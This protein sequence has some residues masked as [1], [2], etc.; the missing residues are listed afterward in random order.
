[1]ILAI[2]MISVVV[3]FG[4]RFV[5]RRTNVEMI[6]VEMRSAVWPGEDRLIQVV[7]AESKSASRISILDL[8]WLPIA[9]ITDYYLLPEGRILRCSGRGINLL[10]WTYP[11]PRRCGDPGPA[12][13]DILQLFERG[14]RYFHG[15]PSA[16]KTA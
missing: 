1:M 9:E 5:F 12:S 13:E 14:F 6:N 4:A 10:R 16:P 2:I 7:Y 11:W 3:S 8:R 15:D